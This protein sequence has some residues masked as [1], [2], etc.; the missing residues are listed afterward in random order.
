MP[1]ACLQIH[2]IQNKKLWKLFALHYENVQ[3]RW[4]HEPNLHLANGGL[5]QLWHGTGA[6]EPHKVYATEQ[7]KACC[8]LCC[9]LKHLLTSSAAGRDWLSNAWHLWL[10][11]D[12]YMCFTAMERQ[13]AWRVACVNRM[14]RD[15]MPDTHSTQHCALWM[16]CFWVACASM[17]CHMC[18]WVF[19]IQSAACTLHMCNVHHPTHVV[20]TVQLNNTQSCCACHYEYCYLTHMLVG[21]GCARRMVSQQA[22]PSIH[23]LGCRIHIQLCPRG[24]P[25]GSWHILFKPSP[26]GVLICAP[27]E[28]QR[29]VSQQLSGW[30]RAC[31][32][33]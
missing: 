17:P 11:L 25:L 28:V 23:H 27:R 8:L 26:A 12:I 19:E 13:I 33:W 5:P 4:S 16:D 3:E 1:P 7:G 22:K 6:T 32:G 31:K 10:Y 15:G 21:S 30:R 14:A 2:R 24:G 9:I 20:H 29:L 18:C